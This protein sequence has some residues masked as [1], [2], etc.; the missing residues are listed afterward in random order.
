[1]RGTEGAG[2]EKEGNQSM[3]D[4]KAARTISPEEGDQDEGG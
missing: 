2:E 4:M 1:M 3:C